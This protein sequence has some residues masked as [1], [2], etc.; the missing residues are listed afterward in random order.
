MAAK[1]DVPQ[2][3]LTWFAIWRLVLLNPTIETFTQIIER[4]QTRVRSSIVWMMI[5]TILIW[6]TGLQQSLVFSFA[7]DQFGLTIAF[8]VMLVGAIVAPVFGVLGLWGLAATSHMLAQ[9]LGGMGTIQQLAYCWA[10]LTPPFAFLSGVVAS[11]SNL[12]LSNAAKQSSRAGLIGGLLV[13]AVYGSVILYQLYAALVA[14]SAVEK[15]GMGTS[16]GVFAL[17]L[18]LVGLGIF[19]LTFLM[20][21]LGRS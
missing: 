10:A 8:R 9:R 4:S 21:V 18:I 20:H 14:Y 1:S 13:I 16:I 3:P 2:A 15:W 11:L 19:V 5:G 7:A 17:Q 6:F 12:L